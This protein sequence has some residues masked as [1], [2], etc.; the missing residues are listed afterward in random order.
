MRTTIRLDPGLM[1]AAKRYAAEAGTTFTAL[2]EDALREV[3]SRK[4]S[5]TTPTH[6]AL[7]TFKGNGFRFN[8]P[9]RNARSTDRYTVFTVSGA[10]R[11]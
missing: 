5:A 7:P 11:F 6:A 8:E 1:K 10:Y 4:R 2:V 9:V 3:L